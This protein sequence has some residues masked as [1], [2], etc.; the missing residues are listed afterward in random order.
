[1][2][3]T[4]EAEGLRLRSYNDT[5]GVKTI[6]YGHNLNNGDSPALL[7][8]MGLDPVTIRNGTQSLT[9]EQADMIFEHDEA[10]AKAGAQRVVSGFGSRLDAHPNWVQN[11]LTD[12]VFNMGAAG[13]ASFKQSIPAILRGDYEAAANS[14]SKS[15]WA[16]QTGRRAKAIIQDLRAGGPTIYAQN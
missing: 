9:K 8:S 11:I 14:L 1:M 7:K 16:S 5:V 4:K 2:V 12:L 15:K 6:G 13:V 10:K 3:S